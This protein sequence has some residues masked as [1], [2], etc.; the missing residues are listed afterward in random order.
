[1]SPRLALPS[2]PPSADEV[3]IRL[4][5]GA[6]ARKAEAARRYS[7]LQGEVDQAAGEGLEAFRVERFRRVGAGDG[8]GRSEEPP[9]YERV[10]EARV[11]SGHYAT[12][13]RR[14]DHVL[15]LADSLRALAHGGARC[16]S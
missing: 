4:D 11:A 12:V 7:A 9:E 6:L 5:D 16:G 1:V 3:V 10:G 14:R 2:L 13:I 15:P 8:D